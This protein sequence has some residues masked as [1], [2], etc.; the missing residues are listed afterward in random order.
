[1]ISDDEVWDVFFE[2]PPISTHQVAFIV[3]SFDC[4]S[5]TENRAINVFA[6]PGCSDQIR[7]V[8]SEAPLL[9]R[10]ME[11]FTEVQYELPVLNLFAVPDLKSDAMGNWGLN[12]YRYDTI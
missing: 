7:N 12:T 8:V 2:S 1:M 11:D 4:L 5:T 10:A 6:R 3:S 9:L